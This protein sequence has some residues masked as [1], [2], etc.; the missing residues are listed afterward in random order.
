L[1]EEEAEDGEEEE[2]AGEHDADEY[3]EGGSEEVI[4]HDSVISRGT[5]PE[6]RLSFRPAPL[7]FVLRNC[8]HQTVHGDR[9]HVAVK[10][11]SQRGDYTAGVGFCHVKAYDVDGSLAVL[12][13]AR[14]RHEAP[15]LNQSNQSAT[16]VLLDDASYWE[17]PDG[18][19]RAMWSCSVQAGRDIVDVEVTPT[20]YH[21]IRVF[22]NTHQF[23][24]F[25]VDSSDG[26]LSNVSLSSE[27]RMHRRVPLKRELAWMKCRWLLLCVAFV[28][29]DPDP[30]AS[31]LI[32]LFLE[33]PSAMQAISRF[34]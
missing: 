30:F 14:A 1:E 19:W 15:W 12:S 3:G 27:S 20:H 8:L 23:G 29:P 16:N 9:I 10:D 6:A 22:I 13:D 28:R 32:K 7:L 34:L 24:W 2:S 5:L 21:D 25:P 31:S 26:E 18:L 4:H 33:I 11:E 17:T